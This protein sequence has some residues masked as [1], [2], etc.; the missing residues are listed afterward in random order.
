ML[1][2]AALLTLVALAGAASEQS[3]DNW[4]IP[5]GREELLGKILGVGEELPG[6]CHLVKGD[7]QFSVVN[8]TY[9]CEG[10]QVVVQFAHP[11]QAGPGP[12]VTTRRFAIRSESGMTP[13]NLLAAL[14]ERATAQEGQFAWEEAPPS[15][16]LQEDQ[17]GSMLPDGPMRYVFGAAVLLAIAALG[18]VVRKA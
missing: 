12:A 14:E 16:P 4:I 7:I 5:P 2:A 1:W 9:D 6:G 8:A 10:S 15:G 13:P 17:L 18:F 11:D 3:E